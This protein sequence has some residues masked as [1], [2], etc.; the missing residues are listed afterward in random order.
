MEKVTLRST[1]CRAN[2]ALRVPIFSFRT[3]FAVLKP[4]HS[5]FFGAAVE[6][7][8]TIGTE[9]SLPTLRGCGGMVIPAVSPTVVFSVLASLR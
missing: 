3:F 6:T 7:C 4:A 5:F 8:I 2:F 9:V 1:G